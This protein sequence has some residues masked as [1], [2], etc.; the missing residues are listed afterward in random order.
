MGNDQLSEVIKFNISLFDGTTNADICFNKGKYETRHIIALFIVYCFK[1][2]MEIEKASKTEKNDIIDILSNI[3]D[4]IEVK[5]VY[6]NDI[7]TYCGNYK[8][9]E[10]SINGDLNIIGVFYRDFD[11]YK[12]IKDIPMHTSNYQLTIS[13]LSLFHNIIDRI[14][15]GYIEEY[16]DEE[17]DILICS[18]KKV[19]SFYW[20]YRNQVVSEDELEVL[21]DILLGF[22]VNKNKHAINILSTTKRYGAAERLEEISKEVDTIIDLLYVGDIEGAEEIVNKYESIVLLQDYI[23]ESDIDNNIYFSSNDIIEKVYFDMIYLKENKQSKEMLFPVRKY[24]YNSAMYYIYIENYDEALVTLLKVLK[25]NPID[26][27]VYMEIAYIYTKLNRISEGFDLIKE[28]AIFAY[29]PQDFARCY[30]QL[31]YYYIEWNKYEEAMACY[32]YS[33]YIYS[34]VNAVKQVEY[35]ISRFNVSER[36]LNSFKMNKVVS[37]LEENNLPMYS[38]EWLKFELILS[39]KIEGFA[40]EKSIKYLEWFYGITKDEKILSKIK[41]LEVH[42]TK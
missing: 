29:K 41:H 25:Y 30:R 6:L 32:I 13:V 21:F 14:T 1:I 24:L 38:N 22:I 5:D 23:I 18:I 35:I 20:D 9:S 19:I 10:E 37:I 36:E 11:K 16:S 7:I 12:I 2:S 8:Y 39:E 3:I 34:N 28:K 42:L 33:N 15:L 4:A 27:E 17:Y 26:I 40:L 31:G